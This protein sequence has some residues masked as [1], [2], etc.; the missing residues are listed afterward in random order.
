MTEK[1]NANITYLG[2]TFRTS[3]TKPLTDE[4]YQEIVDYIN[5]RPS[6]QQAIEELIKVR[7]GGLKMSNITGY[8][9]LSLMYDTRNGQDAWCVND[10]LKKKSIMEYYNGKC[11]VNAQVFA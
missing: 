10:A 7:D 11:A 1:K 3:I 4:E 5:Q 9:F 8:Y 2:R 6:K